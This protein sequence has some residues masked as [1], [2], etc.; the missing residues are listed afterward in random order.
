MS[1]LQNSLQLEQSIYGTT[2][3]SPASVVPTV[4]GPL[5]TIAGGP[6][7]ITSIVAIVTTVFTSTVTTLNVG[8]AAGATT[9]FNAVAL[10]S[11][12]VG[13]SLIGIPT[14]AAPVVAAVG[15]IP[16]IASAG[17]TGQLQIYI[18]YIPVI[19]GVTVV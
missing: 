14:P 12:T 13:A 3:V 16:W 2:L 5:R 17:N 1:Q 6:I 11:L 7:R 19:A 10:T 4:S 15:T 9:L 8:T 18:S